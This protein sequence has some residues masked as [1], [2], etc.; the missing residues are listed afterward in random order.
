V[1]TVY[2]HLGETSLRR[3]QI[4]ARGQRIGTVG[5]TGWTKVPALYYEVRWPLGGLSRPVDPAL[6]TVGLRVEDLGSRLA[7]PLA[8]LPDDFGLIEHL[9]GGEPPR[10]RRPMTGG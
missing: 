9:R 8:G 4:V 1:L 5:R 7:D 3:G 6:V 2:G 10:T